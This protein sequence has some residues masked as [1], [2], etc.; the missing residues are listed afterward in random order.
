MISTKNRV[1]FRAD[2]D[3][4]IGLGHLMRC[5]ALS[6]ILENEFDCFFVIFC[7]S[8]EISLILLQYGEVV[9]LLESNK[10]EELIEFGKFLNKSDI[11]VFDGYLFNE[12]YITTIQNE[13]KAIVQID[14]FAKGYF[15]SDLVLNHANKY[16]IDKYDVSPN[17]KVLCGP[18]YLIL[19]E[20]F[21]QK[22]ATE[23]KE[24]LKVDTAFICMGGA[25]PTNITL[26]VLES[27]I[28]TD[29]IK[30][31]IVV[32]GAAYV[33]DDKLKTFIAQNSQVNITN[34]SN[35]NALDMIELISKAEICV[36]PS[37]SIALEV[38]CVKSGLLTG[39]TVDNQ[40][41]IHEQLVEGN[42][43]ETIDDFNTVSVNGIVS[44][45]KKMNDLTFIN[46]L[47]KNQSI[48]ADGKSGERIL[49]EFKKLGNAKI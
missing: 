25:D 4:T 16:L 8:E 11:V 17:T 1:F 36:C 5:V 47:I 20:E 21:L 24:K 35:I 2:G 37:S 27:F 46:N 42:Y 7:P 12:E 30:N 44:K 19:R 15:H 29:F 14:D 26:K 13:V 45:L 18:D 9:S 33:W 3:S 38:C 31:I 28:Q 39:I 6:Q 40:K 43:A 10:S 22:A 32:T 49:D 48:F 41:L 34:Y 23:H